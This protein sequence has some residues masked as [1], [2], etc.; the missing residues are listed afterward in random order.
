MRRAAP[1]ALALLLALA[2]CQTTGRAGGSSAQQAALPPVDAD[3]ERMIGAAPAILLAELGEPQ[4]KRRE[5]PAEI[6][7]YR[8]E[9]CVLDFFFYDNGGPEI[10]VIHLEARD[11]KAA[12]TDPRVCF[13]GLLRRHQTAQS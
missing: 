11:E 12:K 7:Q 5:T 13:A 9:G 4:L 6:W 1:I 8:G 10:E 2:A 3:T